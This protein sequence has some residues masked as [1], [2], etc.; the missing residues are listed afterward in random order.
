[1]KKIWY[2]LFLFQILNPGLTLSARN[3][4]SATTILRQIEAGKVI[5]YE[6]TDILG[7]L[8]LTALPNRFSMDEMKSDSTPKIVVNIVRMTLTFKNCAFKGSISGYYHNYQQNTILRTRFLKAIIFKDCEFQGESSFQ[9]AEFQGKVDFS[10]SEF[11]TEALFKNVEFK[12][13]VH[14]HDVHFRGDA[15]FRSAVFKKVVNFIGAYFEEEAEFRYAKFQRGGNFYKALFMNKAFFKATEFYKMAF[16]K[17]VQ[18]KSDS[19]FQDAKFNGKE[20]NP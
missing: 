12:K 2:L 3:T 5:N 7:N 13:E 20:F 14:F 9:D 16:F 8:D 6:N 1:M 15:N 18:F 11:Q 10:G 4:V 17:D 19:D